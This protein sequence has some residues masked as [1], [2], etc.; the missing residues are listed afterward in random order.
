MQLL[1]FYAS[2]S[3]FTSPGC[4][5]DTQR[6]FIIILINTRKCYTDLGLFFEPLDKF[7]I[8]KFIILQNNFIFNW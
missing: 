4:Q 2:L 5:N 3:H 8:V 1:I 6:G 7:S